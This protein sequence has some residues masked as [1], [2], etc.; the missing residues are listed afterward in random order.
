MTA[1]GGP[2]V[3]GPAVS[4]DEILKKYEAA[5][6]KAAAAGP[7]PGKAG[8]RDRRADDEH[9]L[10]PDS[11]LKRL[12]E[13]QGLHKVRGRTDWGFAADCWLDLWQQC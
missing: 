3:D 12:M 5:K 13:L 9:R 11:Q 1:G 6:A 2:A 10:M 4:V 8:G 7:K